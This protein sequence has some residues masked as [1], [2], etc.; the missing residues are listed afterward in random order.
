MLIDSYSIFATYLFFGILSVGGFLII[1]V[2]NKLQQK[3]HKGAPMSVLS[4]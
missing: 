3:E 1:A 4:K 2:L